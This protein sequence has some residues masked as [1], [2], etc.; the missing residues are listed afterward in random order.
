MSSISERRRA[1]GRSLRAD[2]LRFLA[3]QARPAVWAWFAATLPAPGVAPSGD[4]PDLVIEVG[5][6]VVYVEIRAS[7]L[8]PLPA[9]RRVWQAAA[10]YR[11]AS[12]ATVRSVPDVERLLLGLGVRLRK[13]KFLASELS[14]HE[15]GRK[16][17]HG[18][19]KTRTGQG[20]A[21]RRAQ[22]PGAPDAADRGPAAL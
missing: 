17:E 1:A 18:E 21:R 10:R 14:R 15:K 6:R 11:G 20:T 13:P 4:R 5:G 2:V 3:F 19:I 22:N 7:H 9:S 12:I 8:G 16:A